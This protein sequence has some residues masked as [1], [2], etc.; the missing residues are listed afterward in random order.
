MTVNLTRTKQL[1][2][3][4]P[5]EGE[6]EKEKKGHSWMKGKDLSRDRSERYQSKEKLIHKNATNKTKYTTQSKKYQ[7]Q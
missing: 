2:T 3:I 7:F 1:T 5:G 4:I 6:K